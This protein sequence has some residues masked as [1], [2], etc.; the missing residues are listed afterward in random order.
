METKLNQK[1]ESLFIFAFS[2][3]LLAYPFTSY[4][5]PEGEKVMAGSASFDRSQANTLNINTPSDK[6]IVNYNSF[7]IAQSETVR[8]YQPS[9]SAIALNRVV[10]VNP[11][12]ILGRLTANGRIFLVNP[13][14][15]LFGQT[16]RVDVAG[17]VVSTLDISND[18]F[19]AGRY[20]F[21]LKPGFAPSY[22]VNRGSIKVDDNGFVVL[23]S[24]LVSNQG[25]IIAHGADVVIAGTSSFSMSFDEQ[26]LI[27]FVI[28]KM[29]RKSGTVTIPKEEAFSLV[30][31]VVNTEGIVE[32]AEIVEEDGVVKL[33]GTTGIAV[34]SGLI[35]VSSSGDGKAGK[36]FIDSCQD[37]VLTKDAFIKADGGLEFSGGNIRIF[38]AGDTSIFGN[39][40]ISAKGG[41]IN[42]KGGNLD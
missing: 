16:A 4:S 2:L 10:G 39:V 32:A 5:L 24:P 22:V 3:I 38:S 42:G 15:I 8:F 11:S 41:R 34:N 37:T 1:R 33:T 6:L 13:N 26:G 35:D 27:N 14:G 31:E 29:D 19:L 23:A 9:S 20:N 40:R 36:V 7:S 21:N 17:L 28:P 12:T 30:E 18:D 25:E